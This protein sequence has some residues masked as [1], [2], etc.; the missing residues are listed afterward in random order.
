MGVRGDLKFP[1]G[2]C[3]VP[4]QGLHLMVKIRV[5]LNV[6]GR[7]SEGHPTLELGSSSIMVQG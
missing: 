2:S 5:T 6:M 7:S 4:L 1:P 3:K